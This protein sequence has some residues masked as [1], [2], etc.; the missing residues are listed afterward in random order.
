MD[1][2]SLFHP[3][4]GINLNA[5]TVSA[6]PKALLE[7]ITALQLEFE[8]NPAAHWFQAWPKL[9][10]AQSRLAGFFKARPEDMFLRTNVTAA[11]N[12][13]IL[14]VEL[15]AGEFVTTNL[16]YGA[17]N[18]ILKLRC[19]NEG[20]ELRTITIPTRATSAD[21][22]VDAVVKGLSD[23][24]RLLLISHVTTGTGLILPIERIAKET[25]RRGIV[26][27]VDGAHGPGST[28]LDFSK[29][30]DVDFYGGNLHKWMMGPKGTGFGWV[31][32]WRQPS[33]RNVQAGWTTFETFLPFS[34]FGGGS[35]F[36]SRMLQAYSFNFALYLALEDLVGFW[37]THGPEK[38]RA[39]QRELRD[40]ARLH[41][42]ALGLEPLHSP[43][44]ELGAPLSTYR[45]PARFQG[46]ACPSIQEVYE[47][48]G[49]NVNLPV[50]DGVRTVR[51][52]PG[53]W[54][55]DPQVGEGV[56]RV[57]EFLRS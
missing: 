57:G 23:K 34:E 41:A 5:G 18:N 30:G 12:D 56:A 2:T 42:D 20:R 22:L 35:A 50:V 38:L 6:T 26:M 52:S 46:D 49:V 54:I 21:E 7:R 13:F 31:P 29:L 25:R 10:R 45:L 1:Y 17:I 14:G 16:E 55:Q 32:E 9:W 11:C 15:G 19:Q 37:E 43:N 33:V 51:F 48:T 28:D 44:P 24:T 8:S 53:L 47:R 36:A 27:V 39:R 40:L 4:T 3:Q